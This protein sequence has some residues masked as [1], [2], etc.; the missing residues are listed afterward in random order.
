MLW[1]WVEAAR[2]R[3]PAFLA[4]LPEGRPLP[5]DVWRR[6]H[7]GIVILLWLHAIALAGYGWYS[8]HELATGFIDFGLLFVSAAL[9]SWARLGRRARSILA[10]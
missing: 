9:A 8:Q 2:R 4:A 6:R 1:G 7:R 10:S 5:A 3:P